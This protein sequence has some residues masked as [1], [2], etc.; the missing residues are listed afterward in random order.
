MVRY[1]NDYKD[2]GKNDSK[3]SAKTMNFKLDDDSLDKIINVFEYIKK[4]RKIDLHTFT[5]ESKGERYLKTKVSDETCFRKDK[6][7]KIN[8]IPNENTKYNC[9]VLLQIQSVYYSIKDKD[10]LK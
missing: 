1:Y 3:C 5:Y 9:R 2:N 8:T 7:N 6:D 4:K 10:I